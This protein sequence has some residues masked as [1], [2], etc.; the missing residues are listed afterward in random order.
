MNVAPHEGD[1]AMVKL[2]IQKITA[3]VHTYCL[4]VEMLRVNCMFGLPAFVATEVGSTEEDVLLGPW[5]R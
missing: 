4:R 2:I 5:P 1:V 3:V